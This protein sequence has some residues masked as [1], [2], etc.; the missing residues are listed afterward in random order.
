MIKEKEKSRM[1]EFDIYNEEWKFA[2]LMEMY[3]N[4]KTQETV[5]YD[6]QKSYRLESILEKDLCFFN[7]V[8]IADL[9]KSLNYT[10]EGSVRRALTYYAKY[11]DW[12]IENGLRGELETGYNDYVNFI[13]TQDLTQYLPKVKITNMYITED[14]LEDIV[15]IL[16][17]PM[18]ATIVQALWE[19]ISG[20]ELFE[21]R[22]IELSNLQ[23]NTLKLL[24]LD[25]STREVVI[26]NKLKN[27][28]LDT[29]KVQEYIL[30]N[31]Y[32][33]RGKIRQLVES[34]YVLKPIANKN[35]HPNDLLNTK[36]LVNKLTAIKRYTDYNFITAKTILYSGAMHK[37]DEWTKEKGLDEPTLAIFQKLEK[38]DT[39]NMSRA[40]TVIL[41]KKYD[42][43]KRLKDS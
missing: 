4:E 43:V 29:D 24:D 27:M 5:L 11:T 13:A 38:P 31:G 10:T 33:V 28:L 7:S 1:A 17:N 16:I 14:E 32:A 42:M 23:G 37:V 35:S 36:M 9:S 12:C 25:G 8:E 3:P 40:Q 26:S 34:K 19:G 15:N 22:T 30:E 39:F 20:T 18:D 21:L 6:F 41:K 2:F